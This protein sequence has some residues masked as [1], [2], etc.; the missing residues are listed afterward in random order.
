MSIWISEIHV[1]QSDSVFI[2]FFP[3]LY[4][5]TANFPIIWLAS[6]FDNFRRKAYLLAWLLSLTCASG[7]G[8]PP[9]SLASRLLVA[10]FWFFSVVIM[11][12]FTANLA[13]FLTVSRMD[14]GIASLD[15]LAAQ[16]DIRWETT[17]T[18]MIIM[19]HFIIFCR[20]LKSFILIQTN[21][22]YG[23]WVN[24]RT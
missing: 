13:A 2:L 5:G 6:L 8:E 11:S 7:G 12:T 17:T 16:S 22:C 20:F 18:T 1:K 23:Q 9:R 4:T 19:I 10:G 3:F 15:K 24:R 21:A 14:T